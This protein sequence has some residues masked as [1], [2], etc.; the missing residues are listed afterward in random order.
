[1]VKFAH[2]ADIHLG[3]WRQP[4]MQALNLQAFKQAIATCI[5]EQV[6]FVLFAGDLFDSAMPSI[7]IL[8]EAISEFRKLKEA[9]IKCYLVPGSHDFSATGK[10]FLDVIEKA[11][12]CKNLVSLEEQEQVIK[13]NFFEDSINGQNILF[14]GIPGKKSSMELEYFKKLKIDEKKLQDYKNNLKIFVFHST[15]TE[16]KPKDLEFMESV[17]MANLP[18]GFDY[19]AAGHLHIVSE[20]NNQESSVIYP[21]PVFPNNIEELEKLSYGSFYLIETQGPRILKKQK[22]NIE[23]KKVLAL[24]IDVDSMSSELANA[25][26]LEELEKQ[27]F[28]DKILVLRI[29][30]TL[31][32]GK[33]SDIDFKKIGDKTK[34]AYCLLK[35]TSGLTTQEL[36]LEVKTEGES[37]EEIEKKFIQEYNSK[38]QPEFQDFSSLILPLLN[39]FDT[40]KQEAE[41]KETFE[42]RILEEARKILNLNLNLA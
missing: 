12:F 2:L 25:K 32:S 31:S 21:G 6:S 38:V 3:G 36:K 4:E 10:T 13:I 20:H 1:M 14:A 40:E 24:T 29:K 7:D 19:Y 39:A 30:G 34:E 16:A 15:L 26:I 33:T 37:I 11:G 42:K 9:G 22:C 35:S 5:S 8:K 23:L 18:L 41:K 17:D 27:N 28:K